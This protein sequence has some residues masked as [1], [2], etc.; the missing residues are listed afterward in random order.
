MQK[1]E[2]L[3]IKKSKRTSARSDMLYTNEIFLD[4]DL[5][6]RLLLKCKYHKKMF[7]QQR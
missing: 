1:A 2:T 6:K 7:S 4:D 3:E 5:A